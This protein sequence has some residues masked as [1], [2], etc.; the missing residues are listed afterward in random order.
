M[1][2]RNESGWSIFSGWLMGIEKGFCFLANNSSPA[3]SDALKF[4]REA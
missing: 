3:D 4:D 1:V 2:G